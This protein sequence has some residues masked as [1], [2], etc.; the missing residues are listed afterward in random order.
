[1]NRRVNNSLSK[2]VAMATNNALNREAIKELRAMRRKSLKDMMGDVDGSD[3]DSNGDATTN[4][5]TF[6]NTL[7]GNLEQV[8]LDMNI[9]SE[10]SKKF[11]TRTSIWITQRIDRDI[12]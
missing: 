10:V 3:V 7:K 6:P 11:P 9:V 2:T 5:S 1:M 8:K 4:S 12:M